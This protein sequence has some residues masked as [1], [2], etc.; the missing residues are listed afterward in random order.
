MLQGE[1]VMWGAV[2]AEGERQGHL[3][4]RQGHNGGLRPALQPH[5]PVHPQGHEHAAGAVSCAGQAWSG[6]TLGFFR[7][8]FDFVSGLPVG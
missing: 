1:C 3:G 6:L 5:R 2:A 8:G 4:Q 7:A